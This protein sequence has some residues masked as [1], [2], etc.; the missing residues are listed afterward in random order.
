MSKNFDIL[1]ENHYFQR[2]CLKSKKSARRRFLTLS[3]T[4]DWVLRDL[5]SEFQS[6]AW[7]EKAGVWWEIAAYYSKKFYCSYWYKLRYRCGHGSYLPFCW[8]CSLPR[9][10]IRQLADLSIIKGKMAPSV[11]LLTRNSIHKFV[12][13][14]LVNYPAVRNF[15]KIPKKVQC[16]YFWAFKAMKY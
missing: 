4:K 14:M 9:L 7:I 3:V 5:Q 13:K 6:F 2:F 12:L 16:F 8:H 15:L 1:Y 11:W 10:F